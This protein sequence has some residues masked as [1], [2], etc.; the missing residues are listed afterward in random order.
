VGLLT[1]LDNGI[2]A[3]KAAFSNNLTPYYARL[4]DGTH[5]YNLEVER[6][7]LLSMLGVG[8]KYSKARENLK[9][10]Y[11]N[12]LFYQD[13]VNLYADLASQVKIME[14][15]QDGNEVENSEFVKFLEN[16]NP[17]QNKTE[18]IRELVINLIVTGAVFQYGN[19]FKNGKLGLSPRLYNL[20]FCN[21]AFP[22]I[23]NRYLLGD[24][25]I[26]NLTIKEHL[27]KNKTRDI[28]FSE[29]VYFYD[30]IPNSGWSEKGYDE[31]GFFKPMA[32]IFSIIPS[33]N[34]LL[35]SQSS[36]E[37]MSGHNVNKII[38][39]DN[40]GN[41]DLAPLGDDQKNDIDAKIN[42]FGKYG[43]KRGKA[44]DIATSSISL[45]ALDL[46]RD[47]RKMQIIEMK[48]S[49]QKDVRNNLLIPEDFFGSSTYE[50]KQHSEA[51]FVLNNVKPCT[52]SWLN[53]LVNKYH[54]YFE[55]KK[56]TLV[57]KYDHIA[58]VM[59]TKKKLENDAFKAKSEGLSNLIGV[60]GSY[61]TSVDPNI[62]WEAF[63]NNNQFNE[64]L[65][66]K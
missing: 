58:S 38:N 60:Y 28:N 9:Y 45:K 18:F 12:T 34:T 37:Y 17:F 25:D 50:N 15:D 46:T 48:E 65:M 22:K 62:T 63:V 2:N 40:T 53:S 64:F 31:S 16:P 14:V 1:K 39:P 11:A 23:E 55:T 19:F 42:G 21:L 5:A 41:K 29:L 3:F 66:I 26:Q 52:D 36:M 47:M 59:E 56:T 57:G 6:Y 7:G 32:R 20:E 30:T 51:R 44:G 49:A 43:M 13:C 54:G 35:N 27:A 24:R 10:Y 33:L 4:D 61:K 8:D